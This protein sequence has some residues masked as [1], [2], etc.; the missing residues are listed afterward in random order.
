MREI[1]RREMDYLAYTL[2]LVARP[3]KYKTKTLMNK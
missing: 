1:I 2:K 3:K